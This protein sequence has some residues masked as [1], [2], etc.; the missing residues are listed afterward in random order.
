MVNSDTIYLESRKDSIMEFFKKYP[1][2]PSSE[3]GVTKGKGKESR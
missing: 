2:R 3:S 1:E